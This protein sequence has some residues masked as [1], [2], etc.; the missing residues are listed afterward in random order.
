MHQLCSYLC[1]NG[2][3][4]AFFMFVK[5]ILLWCALASG[6]VNNFSLGIAQQSVII[7]K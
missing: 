5:V 1:C 6:A 3:V 7:A 2:L 4:D